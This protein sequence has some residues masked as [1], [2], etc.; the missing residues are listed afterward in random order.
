MYASIKPW[1]NVPYQYKSFIKYDGAGNKIFGDL[2]YSMC[3]PAGDVHFVTDVYGKQVVS[4]GQLYLPGTENIKATDTVIFN[5]EERSILRITSY[6]R[7]G[8]ED[9]KVVYI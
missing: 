7:N 3:Y 6:Y 5:G 9:I 4:T 2:V 1:I 8:V